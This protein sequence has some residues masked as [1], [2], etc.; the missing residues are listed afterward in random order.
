M[1]T[2][3][4]LTDCGFT[5]DVDGFTYNILDMHQ[6]YARP[7][8]NNMNIVEFDRD[9]DLAFSNTEHLKSFIAAFENV[10][11]ERECR[12]DENLLKTM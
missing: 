12:N 11:D 1:L 10:A 4:Q 2:Y 3:E 7:E 6:L 8:T 9:V 5:E